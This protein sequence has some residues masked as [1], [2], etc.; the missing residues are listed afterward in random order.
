MELV[1]GLK[2]WK[3]VGALF[4]LC[5]GWILLALIDGGLSTPSTPY[6]ASLLVLLILTFVMLVH[7]VR[8]T[9]SA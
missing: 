4:S 3:E 2:R 6:E 9:A 8:Q 1:N 7:K 5:L